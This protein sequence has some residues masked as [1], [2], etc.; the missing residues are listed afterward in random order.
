M[1]AN[2]EDFFQIT[3]ESELITFLK[4]DLLEQQ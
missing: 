2:R 3:T 4:N 1:N